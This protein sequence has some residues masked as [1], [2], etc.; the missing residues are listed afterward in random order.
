MTNQEYNRDVKRLRKEVAKHTSTLT[1]EKENELKKEFMRLYYVDTKFEIANKETIL[2]LF[3]INL[4][5]RF[6][7]LHL[8]GIKIDL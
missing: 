3:R 5:F 6:I 7:P 4:R 8:F 1:P 2:T